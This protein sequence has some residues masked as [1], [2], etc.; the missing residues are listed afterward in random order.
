MKLR[1]SRA[2]DVR[3][4]LTLVEY[5]A[6]SI[7]KVGQNL[8]SALTGTFGGLVVSTYLGLSDQAYLTYTTIVFILSFWDIFNDVLVGNIID[9][10]K[11]SDARWGRFKPILLWLLIPTAFL[12]IA[13][14]V[15][16]KEFF[17]QLGDTFKV[18]YLVILYLVNDMV[19]TFYNAALT[20]LN[21]RQTADNT[22]RGYLSGIGGILGSVIGGSGTYV[23]AIVAAVL[24]NINEAERY[25]YGMLFF[26]IIAIPATLFN[27]A[28]TK[29]RIVEPEKQEIPPL[30]SVYSQVL[31]NKPLV[32]ITIA[33]VLGS[34]MSIGYGFLIYVFRACF[35]D[36]TLQISVLGFNIGDKLQG[37]EAIMAACSAATIVPTAASLFLAPVIRKWIADKPLYIFTKFWT[38]FCYAGM[39]VTTF[40]ITNFTPTQLFW[41]I[42]FWYALHG[43]TTGLYSVVPN[44]LQLTAYDYGEYKFGQRNEAT[45]SALKSTL[46]KIVGSLG[47]YASSWCLVLIGYVQN[48]TEVANITTDTKQWLV[49]LFAVF[50]AV[51]SILAILPMLFYKLNGKMQKEMVE[52][53]NVRRQETLDEMNKE[54]LEVK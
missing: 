42:T 53:L 16:L 7:D 17:P 3:E 33:D 49:A 23:A 24:P 2:T 6:F 9:R 28:V 13:G 36:V 48:G 34:G 11:K 44:M 26:S 40:P 47:N 37:Y 43:I 27:I 20:A 38:F 14:A 32:L 52:E 5:A 15:P 8:K 4:K 39:F 46:S 12:S 41:R 25:F 45:V 22:E 29:E 54:T 10:R 51:S 31:K 1:N 50:P 21:A 19:S 30:R 35:S 18:V